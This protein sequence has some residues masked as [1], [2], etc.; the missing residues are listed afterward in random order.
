MK[1]KSNSKINQIGFVDIGAAGQINWR[2]KK[3]STLINYIGFE[4][5]QRSFEALKKHKNDF[6]TY[7]I[8]NVAISKAKE[9]MK[10]NLCKYPQMSSAFKPNKKLLQ[11]YTKIDSYDI[12]SI[13]KI[14]TTTLDACKIQNPDFIKIDIQGCEL[15][16]LKGAKKTLIKSLGV[17][18]EVEFVDMYRNQPLFN[19]IN[20]YLSAQGFIFIDFISAHR[21]DRIG[22]DNNG[23]L[24]GSGQLIWADALYLRPP[25]SFNPREFSADLISKYFI[26]CTLYKR[27]DMIDKL[28]TLLPSDLLED[29]KEFLISI[30]KLKKIDGHFLALQNFI[31]HLFRLFGHEYKCYLLK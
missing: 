25:E 11:L 30:A 9:I 29:Q 6:L 15:K 14:K 12:K 31:T 8:F 19:N 26:I 13:A 22:H 16:A 2:W 1:L 23:S 20:K 4:P 21:W 17:E 7:V 10:V 18:V 24:N 28:V 5:D 27:L 3:I